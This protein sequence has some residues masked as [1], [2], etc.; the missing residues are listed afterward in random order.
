LFIY[1]YLHPFIIVFPKLKGNVSLDYDVGT[2]SFCTK[3]VG[4]PCSPLVNA[5]LSVVEP[6]GYPLELAKSWK[7]N[8]IVGKGLFVLLVTFQLSSFKI[9]VFLAVYLLVLQFLV[10]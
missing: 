10:M 7:R 4:Q 3:V 5:L 1:D 2:N 6:F 8:V 9:W